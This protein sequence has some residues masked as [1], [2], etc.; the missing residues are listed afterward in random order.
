MTHALAAP[1]SGLADLPGSVNQTLGEIQATVVDVRALLSESGPDLQAG[2]A[3]VEAATQ[4]LADITGSLTD[5]L[6]RNEAEMEQF[7]G[8][9]LGQVP[10][11]ISDIRDAVR[12]ME[13]LLADIRREPS[14]L[15]Y[16]TADGA[17]PVE[18]E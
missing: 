6:D 1:E 8:E 15:I 7:V 11:L 17:V 16:Q 3:N 5:W 14:G 10:A 18:E 12:E 4:N 9:G 2:L 13:K